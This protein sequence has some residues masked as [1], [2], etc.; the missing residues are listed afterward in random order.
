M[1]RTVG[2]AAVPQ[3]L[4]PASSAK[5]SQ[6]HTDDSTI[7]TAL[8]QTSSPRFIG[9]KGMRKSILKNGTPTNHVLSAAEDDAVK[10]ATKE[11]AEIIEEQ[12]E[13]VFGPAQFR[14][15]VRARFRHD[16]RHLLLVEE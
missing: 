4:T 6:R 13:G 3:K 14:A 1:P 7:A 5:K 8:L 9:P 12:A 15:L 10:V 11:A 2:K 16:L